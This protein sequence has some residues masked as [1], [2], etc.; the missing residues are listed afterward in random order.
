MVGLGLLY[1]VS[2]LALDALGHFY[3]HVAALCSSIAEGRRS[4]RVAVCVALGRP[5]PLAGHAQLRWCGGSSE[6]G[7]YVV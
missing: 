5:S 3:F 4:G 6:L 7:H 1:V 2:H